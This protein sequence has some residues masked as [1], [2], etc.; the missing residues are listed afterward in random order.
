MD[1]DFNEYNIVRLLFREL[2]TNY[3]EKYLESLNLRNYLCFD[4][5]KLISGTFYSCNSCQSYYLCP[6]CEELTQHVHI[7]LKHTMN[8]P[9]VF[10]VEPASSVFISK[11][12]R[13]PSNPQSFQNLNHPNKSNKETKDI[14]DYLHKL[15]Y[16]GFTDSQSSINALID[17]DYNLEK[18]V[19]Q[20]LKN[21]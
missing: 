18:V 17:F 14:K 2:L 7:L 15:S 8:R 5:N 4:C 3:A 6:G 11:K 12:N 21:Q 19:E 20:L 1:G 16:M 10:A 9:K 13:N